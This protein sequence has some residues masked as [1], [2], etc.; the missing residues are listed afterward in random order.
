MAVQSILFDN[1]WSLFDAI[2]W[3]DE[4]GF[5]HYKVDVTQNKLRFRQYNPRKTEHYRTK[6][7][8][9]NIG[10]EFI[11]GFPNEQ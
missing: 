4:H 8:G 11:L 2:D 10:I 6:K 1:R 3:L 5:K 9:K 7:I